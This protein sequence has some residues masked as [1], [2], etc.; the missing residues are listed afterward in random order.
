MQLFGTT[1]ANSFNFTTFFWLIVIASVVAMIGRYIKIPYA[2]ALVITGLLV[3]PSHILPQ[4]H[5]D[6][7]ILFT[8]FLP[9]LLFES[10]IHMRVS[11]LRDN[12]KP[13]TIYAFAGTIAS[14]FI[15]GFLVSWL[16]KIP[17]LSAL[18][19]GALISPTDPISVISIFKQL[20]VGKRLSLMIEAESLF[21]DGVAIVIF[22]LLVN[23]ALGGS[24]SFVSSLE[25]FFIVVLGGAGIGGLIGFFASRLTRE[26]DDHLLEITMTTIV[27]FGSYLA[28][29]SAG[30]SGVIAVVT[31]G[32]LMGSY[33]M[34]TG[35][36]PTTKLSVSSFWEYAAFVVNSIVFLIVGFEVTVVHLSAAIPAVVAAFVSVL[37][38][39]A[40]AIYGLSPLINS[41]HGGD[42]PLAWQHVFF[43]GGFR[44]AI[45][46][47]LV[48][49]LGRNFPGRDELVVMTFGVVLISLLLQGLTLKPLM[50]KIGIGVSGNTLS[51]F[52]RL[53]SEIFSI[54]GALKELKNLYAIKAIST[55][56][57]ERLSLEYNT[58]IKNLENS[59]DTLTSNNHDLIKVQENEARVVALKAEK[60]ALKE[61]VL[62]G[63][64]DESDFEDLIEKIDRKLEDLQNKMI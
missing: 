14:T 43:W 62:N 37:I 3:G 39:R 58:R 47:A 18:V 56:T 21:N 1:A 49:G 7:H 30:V 32:L 63:L 10:A 51:E 13:V 25:S 16:L 20:G 40:V 48:I 19:F 57:C 64:L 34:R 12:W 8:V 53:S 33:G 55:S 2:L 41:M 24:I 11:L 27:A 29:E 35:M 42:V 60:S 9:P 52:R 5:L 28:A 50:K 44:G 22:S 45:P 17:I 23:L 4:V 15:V 6:P 36:S 26:F 54:E 31:A 61:S 59:L 46:M 38:G